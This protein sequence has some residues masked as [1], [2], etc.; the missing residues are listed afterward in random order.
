MDGYSARGPPVRTGFCRPCG[1][2]GTDI[3]V[4]GESGQA[5]TQDGTTR[6]RRSGRRYSDCRCGIRRRLPPG[7]CNR[8]FDPH[9]Q[10]GGGDRFA[11]RG[12]RITA[13]ASH[14]VDECLPVECHEVE[15]VASIR[16]L[17]GSPD[18]NRCRTFRAGLAPGALSK[19]K[20]AIES[21]M[22]ESCDL[23]QLACIEGLSE[24][25]FA[26]AFKQSVGLPPHRYL[27]KLR[28]D[29]AADLIRNT[30]RS[31]TDVSLEVGFAD[32]SHFTR[33]FSREMGETPSAFRF[34][35]C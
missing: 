17:I 22:A 33:T 3:G 21:R 32:Q 13:R 31:L 34:R 9:A 26:R 8:Y 14:G 30:D 11:G 24:G 18:G 5:R 20:Q 4:P 2:T 25:H 27:L 29:A 23:R 16:R 10:D 12:R 15:L 7:P 35:H 19:I 28:V 6:S 1:H